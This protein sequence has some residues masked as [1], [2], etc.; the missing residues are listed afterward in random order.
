MKNLMDPCLFIRQVFLGA[1][2][3]LTFL[4]TLKILLDVLQVEINLIDDALVRMLKIILGGLYLIH[5]CGDG[6][7]GIVDGSL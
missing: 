3:I 2:Y 5:F 4:R 1:N 7:V 6:I